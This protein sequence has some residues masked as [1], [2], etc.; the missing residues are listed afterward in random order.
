MNLRT[1]CQLI[2]LIWFQT[3]SKNI[4]LPQ[5]FFTYFY[6][7]SLTKLKINVE[8]LMFSDRASQYDLSN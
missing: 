2:N 6:I 7:L 1:S 5:F 4:K 3:G 8:V